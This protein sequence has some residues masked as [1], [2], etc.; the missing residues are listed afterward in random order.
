[1][2]AVGAGVNVCMGTVQMWGAGAGLQGCAG[3]GTWMQEAGV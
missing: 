3:E 1:M 2:R